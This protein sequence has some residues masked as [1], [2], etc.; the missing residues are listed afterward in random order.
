MIKITH[1]GHACFTVDLNNVKIVFDPYDESIGLPMPHIVAEKL[2]I[3]H[4]HYDHNNASAVEIKHV[5]RLDGPSYIHHEIKS[6]HDNESGKKRGE[7]IIRVVRACTAPGPGWSDDTEVCNICHL[8]DLGQVL[9]DDQVAEIGKVDVLL[10]PVGGNYTINA[11]QA[12]EVVRQLKPQIT[13]P[14]HYKTPQTNL[15]IA[16]LDEFLKLM[17][18]DG[19]PVQTPGTNS[20]VYSPGLSGVVV[21]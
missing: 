12:R 13:I 5:M 19:V 8:G 7:N 14:M 3:S 2:F 1:I 18:N 20:L 6:W 4:N 15:D 9:T 21:I 10:I 16:P 17:A 11:Q